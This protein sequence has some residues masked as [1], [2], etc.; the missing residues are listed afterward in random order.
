MINRLALALVATLA[1]A[2]GAAAQIAVVSDAVEEKTAAAGES[3]GGTIR[4]LNTSGRAQEVKV[5]QTDY[6]FHADGRTM[7]GEPGTAPRSN[8]RWVTM[9]PARLT[10]APGAESTVSFRV[11]IPAAPARSGS[12]WSMV[13]VE[14]IEAGSAE[15][16]Q[17]A[18]SRKAELSVRTRTRFGV[19][20]VT[21]L[22]EEGART[23]EFG[24]PRASKEPG[25][26]KSLEVDLAN[27]GDRAFRPTLRLELF[28]ADGAPA[29]RVESGRGLVYP[30]TSLRQ[31]FELGS[32]PAGTY[33]ALVVAD[34]GGDDVFGARYKVT[35]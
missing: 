5:Y 17:R 6:A 4:I 35:F 31:R 1:S 32:I 12:F 20:V 15:S 33:D 13:M 2:G 18:P 7:Y 3:Y 21:H 23:L 34:A 11:A 22:G 27:T 14:P 24:A 16:S 28:T 26:A 29:G 19:Q 9:S 10:L 30:G 25:G 8:A